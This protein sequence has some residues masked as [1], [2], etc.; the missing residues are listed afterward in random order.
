M[1]RLAVILAAVLVVFTGSVAV[2]SIPSADG[3]LYGCVKADG[4]LVVKD[5]AGTGDITCGAQA[6]K[7]R[8]NQPNQSTQVT[9][10]SPNSA[11]PQDAVLTCPAGTYAAGPPA[12][13]SKISGG[14]Y[15]VDN[16]LH[17]SLIPG[18][19]AT[20]AV[21]D[22]TVLWVGAAAYELRAELTCMS[23]VS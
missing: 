17:Y 10:V 3:T 1:R 23:G 9:F 18:T 19:D 2:A 13:A 12:I 22:Y 21:R 5:D 6:T 14:S 7:I 15:A 20:G 16:S 8:F 11:T 4:T